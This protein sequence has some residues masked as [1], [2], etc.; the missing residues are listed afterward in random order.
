M[1]RS[2]AV[3]GLALAI[4]AL[5][6][7]VL[8]WWNMSNA[9]R[10]IAARLGEVKSSV[11]AVNASLAES[12]KAINKTLGAI[13]ETLGKLSARVERLEKK[14]VAEKE[15]VIV[16]VDQ[17]IFDFYVDF[18][19][20]YVKRLQF[21]NKTAGVILLINSPGGAVGAT[22]R[23]YYTIKGLN[24]TV[25]AVVAG[26]GASGAYYTAVAAE[27][28]YATPS[29]WVGSIGVIALLWPDDYLI[30]L[31]DY[32]YTTGPFKYYG[33]DLT[34]FYNDI[35]K[36]RANF[37]AAVLRG[38]G[39]RLKAGSEVFETARI[40]SAGDALR[41]G[42]I[43]KIG[44]LWDAVRDVAGELGL[45][46]YTVVDI[47]EKYNVT[48]PG[49]LIIPLISGKIPLQLLL[50]ASA[51]PIFYLWPG[52]V[53][54]PPTPPVDITPPLPQAA[55]EEKRP[56][57]PY[58]V[59]DLSHGNL[60]PR[61]FV[62]VLAR[63]L[64]ER[65]YAL[66]VARDEFTL[67]KLLENATGLIVVNPTT[68][69]TD[70][71]A[72]AVYNATL[73]GVRVLYFAD[74]RA[75][76]I[77]AVPSFIIITPYSATSVFDPLLSY[78]NVTVLRA[79]YNFSGL[80]A[81]NFTSNWQY[82]HADGSAFNASR[83]ILLSPTAFAAA[84]GTQLRVKAYMFGYGEGI[85]TVAVRIGNFTAIGSVRSFTPYFIQLGDNY[86]FFKNLIN[87]LIEP[88]PIAPPPKSPEAAH[89]LP[90]PPIIPPIPPVPGS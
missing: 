38:R 18:L 48:R 89:T 26:L 12:V 21:D 70:A 87:W 40:F 77:A 42:L 41:L 24:K 59:L 44:G 20:K 58:V 3:A 47:Y 1:A 67:Q 79:V 88:R 43:D 63:E 2:L 83:L 52:A 19:I 65:G 50:N 55:G 53:E 85:Y 69:F 27:R 82:V 84:S 76:G 54:I 17:P 66:R 25:Y 11:E 39:D 23:L 80:G 73:R 49:I 15:I 75:S 71:V 14:A 61:G 16:P 62:E 22:E 64:V 90:T 57:R 56:H 35:E 74:M 81:L 8:L 36:T 31:P 29:S 6:L 30:D 33:M 32:L 7:G 86:K 4:A 72:D 28:I 9:E 51:A 78:F 68:P 34:E 37:V 10:A 5:V 45:K 13:N 46:N 60:M